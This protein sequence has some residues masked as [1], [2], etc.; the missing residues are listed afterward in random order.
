MLS[1]LDGKALLRHCRRIERRAEQ[2]VV[3]LRQFI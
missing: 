3:M 2:R 1:T